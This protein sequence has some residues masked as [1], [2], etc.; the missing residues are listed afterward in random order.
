MKT[1]IVNGKKVQIHG[2]F[3]SYDDII[4]IAYGGGL[5]KRADSY[6][7]SAS[8]TYKYPNGKSGTMQHL[9]E[10]LLKDGT[11]FNAINTGNA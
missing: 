3:I 10:I 2:K 8:M 9:D 6:Y 5:D 1:I 11:V 7:Y 4:N